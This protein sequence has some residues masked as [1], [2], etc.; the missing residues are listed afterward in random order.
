MIN[1]QK[2]IIIGTVLGGSSLVLPSNGNNAYL[3]MRSKNKLWLAYKM[4]ELEEYFQ[5]CTHRLEGITYRCNSITSPILTDIHD[6]MYQNGKR[7]ITD[8]IL[9]PLMDIGLAIWYLDGGG[10]CGRNQ[11]NIYLNTTKLGEEGTETVL[12]YF[13]SMFMNCS[14]T[15]TQHRI[16]IVFT[17]EASE[18]YARIIED[19][20]PLFMIRHLRP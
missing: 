20:V 6:K 2:N 14:K 19:K 16:R 9:D 13:N 7:H 8:L 1:W 11:K 18:K 17:V 10:R 15:V 4:Q 12:E 5:G 3:S